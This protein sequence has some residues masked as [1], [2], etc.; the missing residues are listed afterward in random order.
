LL[1]YLFSLNYIIFYILN[2]FIYILLNVYVY[3]ILLIL[4][5]VSTYFSYINKFLIIL[6]FKILATNSLFI[7]ELKTQVYKIINFINLSYNMY[8]LENFIRFINNYT[9]FIVYS[10]LYQ[11][12]SSSNLISKS[13]FSN[14]NE[15]NF[16]FFKNN[17]STENSIYLLKYNYSLFYN[18]KFRKYSNIQ[19]FNVLP[20]N[21]NLF[22]YIKNKFIFNFNDK[23][24]FLS[25]S[26]NIFIGNYLNS[27]KNIDILTNNNN[28]YAN[29]LNQVNIANNI[30]FSNSLYKKNIDYSDIINFMNYDKFFFNYNIT[31]SSSLKWNQARYTHFTDN[32]VFFNLILKNNDSSNFTNDDNRSFCEFM[33]N[34]FCFNDLDLLLNLFFQ[35]KC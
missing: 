6:N 9:K 12:N 19:N 5:F 29:S 7:F 31:N 28:N 22:I 17:L 30:Q 18:L 11:L 1:N 25:F 8:N 13:N 3:F 34:R 32:K 16:F 27:F 4:L 35:N 20:I 14:L 2:F 23:Q 15:L 24:T 10:L 21:N 33:D 26:N